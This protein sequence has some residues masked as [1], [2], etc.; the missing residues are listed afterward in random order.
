MRRL[1]YLFLWASLS[2]CQA[3]Y[4]ASEPEILDDI[5]AQWANSSNNPS[6]LLSIDDWYSAYLS[7]EQSGNLTELIAQALAH[8]ISI[9]KQA[10]SVSAQEKALNNAQAELWPSLSLDFSSSRQQGSSALSSSQS[11]DL[12]ASYELDIWGKLKS[13][14][15]VEAFTYL[16]TQAEL[17]KTKQSVV[18]QVITLY[19]QTIEAKQLYELFNERAKNSQQN[20]DIIDTGYKQGLNSALDVYLA[21]NEL[22]SDLATVSQQL[23]LQQQLIRQLENLIGFYPK[24]ALAFSGSIPYLN[25]SVYLGLPSQLTKHNPS[26]KLEWLELLAANEQIAVAHKLR[27]P[28]AQ[29]NASIGKASE[30]LSDLLSSDTVWSLVGSIVTPIFNAGKLKNNVEIAKLSA[31]QFELDYLNELRATFLAVENALFQEKSL[32]ERYEYQREA[33][34]NALAAQELSFEQYQKGLV[35]Y[36]TVLEAQTRAVDAQSSLIQITSSLFTNRIELQVAL[37]SAL[38]NL[39]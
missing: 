6:E 29:I 12:S 7:S 24:G 10:L 20:L 5:P 19:I 15:K 21:R 1:T 18:A 23:N 32:T 39:N 17:E 14:E 22:N 4:Q 37:G 13:Q 26:L 34:A 25:D 31:Q 16:S 11:L 3:T 33:R 2:A 28:S 27:F 8:N 9:Q 30:D 35:T 36:T 38:H